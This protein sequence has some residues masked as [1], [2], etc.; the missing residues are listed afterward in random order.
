MGETHDRATQALEAAARGRFE[1]ASA[2][3][4]EL[5]GAGDPVARAWAEAIA[6]ERRLAGL[7][8]SPPADAE[9]VAA[10]GGTGAGATDAAS[11][12]LVRIAREHLLAIDV[13][14]A[15]S[16]VAHAWRLEPRSEATRLAV[17]LGDVLVRVA[18][19][20]H[21][22]MEQPAQRVGREASA[23]GIAPLVVDATSVRALAALTRDDL[24]EAT[25]TARRASR[26]ARTES[27]PQQEYLANVVLARVRRRTGSPHLA[28]RILAALSRVAP[29][30][31]H[32]WLAWELSMAGGAERGEGLLD[33]DALGPGSPAAELSAA[34]TAAH[35]GSRAGWD[36]AIERLEPR[37]SGFAPMRAD[38]ERLVHAIDP[39]RDPARAPDTVA[40]W[41]RAERHEPPDGIDGLVGGLDAEGR[42]VDAVAHVIRLPDGSATRVLS[43][44]IGLHPA[45]EPLL[46][47]VLGHKRQGRPQT[48]LPVLALAGT[49]GLDEPTLFQA[50]YGFR[51]VRELHAT[52]LNVMLHRLRGELPDA[53][54]LLRDDAGLCLEVDSPIAVPDPRCARRLEDRVLRFLAGHGGSSARDAAKALRVPLRS[55]QAA[56]E[57]LVGDGALERDRVGRR[58]GYRVEDTTFQEPTS[59]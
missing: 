49:A 22:G 45:S 41:R 34:L 2:L 42:P 24:V 21:D 14:R 36:S 27:L 32:P 33:R 43:P 19:G 5:G 47:V 3:L 28:L 7:D 13:G 52:V 26:M 51:Y 46:E 20:E 30:P 25:A 8:A 37:V 17:E 31:W 6:S 39:L 40:T 44:G 23:R 16:A 29:R 55:A 4:G 12:A 1:P 18:G 59:H 54:R 48:A 10:L 57:A 58:V 11:E 50:V 15:A 35:E 38:A 53:V 9:A 56:L